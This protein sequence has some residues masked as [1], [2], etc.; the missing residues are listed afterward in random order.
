MMTTWAFLKG[1]RFNKKKKKNLTC[2]DIQDKPQHFDAMNELAKRNAV[3]MTFLKGDSTKMSIPRTDMLF[4]DTTHHYAQLIRELELHS[5]NVRK[6]IVMHNTEIDGRYG[7]IVR[8]CYYYDI[9]EL[10]NKYGYDVNDMCK[11]LGYAIEDFL[12]NHP[13]WKVE[14]HWPNNNGLTI[15][16]KESNDD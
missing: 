13:E 2:I 16:V 5:D 4:V 3:N 11:G 12:Q 6:Y 15:L 1:L 8:M 14:K 9:E 7:E 10:K